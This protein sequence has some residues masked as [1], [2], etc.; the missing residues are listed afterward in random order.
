MP[1][2]PIAPDE[3]LELRCAAKLNTFLSVGPIDGRGYHPIR[4]VFQAVDGADMLRVFPS[5]RFEFVCDSAQVPS[6]NTVTKAHRMVCELVDLPPLRVELVK[7]IPTQSGLGGGSS[8]AAAML[9]VCEVLAGG[10]L[11]QPELADVALAVGADVPFFLVGGRAYG[12]GYGERLTPLEDRAG[13]AVLAMPK[14]ARCETGPMYQALDAV[15]FEW[16]EPTDYDEVYNDFERV[17]PCECLDLIETIQSAG[18]TRAGLT[19]S[20][21]AVFAIVETESDANGVLAAL[22]GHA[23]AWKSKLLSRRE[24]LPAIVPSRY[25]GSE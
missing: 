2:W 8:N 11:R 17:A 16:R 21:A 20:G 23:E 1:S 19:G 7:A 18:A 24:S 25:T 10:K 13:W 12:E 5:D 9:R 4:T 22:Q 6:Q 14:H 15:A 3:C